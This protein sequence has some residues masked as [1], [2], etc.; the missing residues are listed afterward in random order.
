[1]TNKKRDEFNAITEFKNPL[2]LDDIPIWI[3][4]MQV[5]NLE[6][7]HNEN[8]AIVKELKKLND[9]KNI[10]FNEYI[11]AS[12]EEIMDWGIYNFKNSEHRIINID[13]I[14]EKKILERLLLSE[15]KNSIDT[16]KYHINGN[17]NSVYIKNPIYKENNII[18]KRKIDFDI[19]VTKTMIIVGFFLSHE[20]EFQNTLDWDLKINNISSGER[21]KDFYNNITYKF[22]EVATFT[23]NEKNEY[24]KCSIVEYYQNKGQEYIVSKLD[25]NS[26]AILVENNK[27][28]IFPYIPNRLKKVCK[29]E[30]LDNKTMID[31][32]KYIKLN[33]NNKM[34]Q[35]IDIT[36]DILINSKY[37]QLEK[38]NILIDALGYESKILEKPTFKFR[39]DKINTSIFYGLNQNGSY[40]EAEIKISYFIDPDI[41]KN[42]DKY[43]VVN[44]FANQIELYS[45]SKGVILKRQKSGVNFK[46]I[47]TQN[48]DLFEKDIR[49]IVSKYKHPV[50]II[51]DDDNLQ[52]YYGMIKK[53][54]GNK[55]NIAT[56]FIGYKTL[57]YNEKNKNAIFLNTLLGVYGKSGI[58]PWILSSELNA[59]C[60]IGLDVSRENKLNTAGMIQIIGKDGR[61][62]KSKSIT[63]SQSGEKISSE[64]LKDIFFD[65]ITEY[66]SI[67]GKDLKHIVFH[68]DGLGIEDLEPLQNAADNL[69]IK[70][71]YIEV[72]KNV[73]RRVA[74]FLRHEKVWKTQIGFYIKKS[75]EAYIIT[76]NPYEKIGMAQPLRIKKVCGRQSIDE[77]VEDIYKLSFMHIGSILKSRLPVTTYYADLSSTYG[78]R[79]WIPSIVNSN[80]LH[81]I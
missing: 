73:K 64:T 59:D 56:Q 22:K 42:N 61:I 60:Y 12:F 33:S 58:Q 4:T 7:K 11:I 31:C 32:N 72:T 74:T 66:K 46:S 50:L 44:N 47:K 70:F 39:R 80:I 43:K 37:I 15:L 79:E 20:F 53:I 16:K 18:L 6:N 78:N 2:S 14:T 38:K 17:S 35:S 71:D 62:L 5:K 10:V 68:R 28:Q 55:N 13:I 52:K 77:I 23:I 76:T 67:Y 49:E 54:F 24:M 48:K 40:E 75:D 3:Y 69:G 25:K 26:N 57:N 1:M 8:Y 36:K 21:V 30:N 29:F 65:A 9:N 45:K 27:G 19:N 34:Q 51:M 63:S 41:I 81:F